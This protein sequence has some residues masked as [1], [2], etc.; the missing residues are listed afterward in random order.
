VEQGLAELLPNVDHA[1][2]HLVSLSPEGG[3]IL[4]ALHRRQQTWLDRCTRSLGRADL[5]R[6]ADLLTDLADRVEQ[7]TAR[8][9]A[10]A[11]RRSSP[12]V[13]AGAPGVRRRLVSA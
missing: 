7:A 1:R 2:A 10:A 9:D 5:E 4:A 13:R 11:R 6:A 3:R 8:E 12:G